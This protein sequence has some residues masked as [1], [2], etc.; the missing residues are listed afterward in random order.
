MKNV[1]YVLVILA[2]VGVL[3]WGL[4][5]LTTQRIIEEVCPR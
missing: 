2:L 1:G 3:V 5:W 4:D